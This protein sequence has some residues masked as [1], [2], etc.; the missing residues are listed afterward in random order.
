MSVFARA[1]LASPGTILLAQAHGTFLKDDADTN[2]ALLW[3]LLIP[4]GTMGPNDTLRVWHR[5]GL[6]NNANSKSLRVKIGSTNIHGVSLTTTASFYAVALLS[7]R[8]AFNTQVGIPQSGNPLNASTTALS[9]HAFDTTQDMTLGV[10]AQHGT[11]AAG[12]QIKLESI[13][14]ELLKS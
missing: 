9:F 10:F 1:A 13:I 7:N 4:G 14:V 2:E 5:W 11:A 6:T 3:S 8:G 12:S